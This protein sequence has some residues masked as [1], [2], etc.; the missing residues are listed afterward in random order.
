MV[1]EDLPVIANLTPAFGGRG[2]WFATDVDDS[3]SGQPVYL[4]LR[5]K[6]NDEMNAKLTLY[7]DR[8]DKDDEAGTYQ[9]LVA[10]GQHDYLIRISTNYFWWKWQCEV[11]DVDLGLSN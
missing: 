4:W 8:I 11:C 10:K 1:C 6:S 2:T 7:K 9:F 5:I 3:V